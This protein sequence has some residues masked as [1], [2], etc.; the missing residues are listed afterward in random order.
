[1]LEGVS[2]SREQGRVEPKTPIPKTVME[3]MLVDR[4]DMKKISTL[5]VI[6]L[7]TA[8]KNNEY[9]P[10]SPSEQM[11]MIHLQEHLLKSQFTYEEWLAIIHEAAQDVLKPEQNPVLAFEELALEGRGLCDFLMLRTR[12]LILLAGGKTDE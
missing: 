7:F 12:N 5:G 6:A 3:K 10:D 4:D 2:R 11:L 1:M 8:A 9:N